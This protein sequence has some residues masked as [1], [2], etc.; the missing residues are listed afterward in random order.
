MKAREETQ[1]TKSSERSGGL[2]GKLHKNP[3]KAFIFDFDDTL[4]NTKDISIKRHKEAVRRLGI[5]FDEKE[6]IKRW[7]QP[8]PQMLSEFLGDGA[9]EFVEIMKGLEDMGFRQIEGTNNFLSYLKSRNFYLGILTSSQREW[10]FKKAESASI[11]IRNFEDW[12]IFCNE[13]VKECKPSASAF[14]PIINGLNARGVSKEGIYY[15]GDLILDLETARNAGVNFI[16]VTTGFHKKEDFIK[17]G[18]GGGMIIN[19]I[20]ELPSKIEELKIY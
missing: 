17:A 7:G 13:D 19:S 15:C 9:K 4:I 6:L 10:T 20:K 12:L 2:L 1:K 5:E 18:L 11:D 14:E 16:A 3:K 8:W